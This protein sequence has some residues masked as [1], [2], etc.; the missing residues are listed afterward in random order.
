MDGN[1]FDDD[2]LFDFQSKIFFTVMFIM[3]IFDN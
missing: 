1:I 3:T 2:L